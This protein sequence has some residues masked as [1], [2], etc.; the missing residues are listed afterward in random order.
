VNMSRCAVTCQGI[1]LRTFGHYPSSCF[2]YLKT[3]FQIMDSVSV[4]R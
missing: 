2:F 3:M 4:P 1:Q